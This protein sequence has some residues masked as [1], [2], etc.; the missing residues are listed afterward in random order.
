MANGVP[1]ILKFLRAQAGMTQESLA[2]RLHV[3]TSLIAKFE[4][5]RLVPMPDTA[6]QIDGVFSSGDLVQETANEARKSPAEEWF[7]PWVDL[8]NR[9]TRQQILYRE[10]NPVQLIV[11]LGESALRQE[12]GDP[13]V[14]HRQLLALIEAGERPNVMVQV[15]P[16]GRA[17]PGLNGSF[18]LAAVD[19]RTVG[20]IDGPLDGT[21]VESSEGTARLD[22]VWERIRGYALPVDQSHELIMKVAEQWT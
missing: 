11:V 12:I 13:E 1:R 18:V 10:E 8:A 22:Q 17:H 16:A 19:G 20:F 9:L 5:A 7:R 15:I 3:S 2:E 21:V 6:R 4:T 14:M